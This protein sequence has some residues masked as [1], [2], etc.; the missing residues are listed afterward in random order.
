M[1]GNYLLILLLIIFRNCFGQF[2]VNEAEYILVDGYVFAENL[3]HK[4]TN[5]KD[6]DSEN[7]I[8]KVD[9]KFIYSYKY[10]DS[11]KN[12]FLF[13]ILANGQ[14]DFVSISSNEPNIVRNIELQILPNGENFSNPKFCQTRIGY[15]LQ[16]NFSNFT[17]TGLIENKKNIWLH[18]PRQYLF[19]ILELNPFH[20]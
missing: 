17:T 14:W 9:K 3:E 4:K 13:K 7:K 1:K 20:T 18:P 12:A 19:H 16:K 15:R 2:P 10:L 11:Q 8:F 5:C 6:C